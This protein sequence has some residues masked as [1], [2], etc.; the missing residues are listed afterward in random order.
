MRLISVCTVGPDGAT[1]A[2]CGQYI[3]VNTLV[4]SVSSRRKSSML[5]FLLTR[6]ETSL[7]A[8]MCEHYFGL[9][10]ERYEFQL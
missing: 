8:S 4:Q 1:D 7:W 6:L 5:G 2:S 3:H 9:S 10:D